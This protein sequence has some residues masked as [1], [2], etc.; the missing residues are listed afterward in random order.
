MLRRW[1]HGIELMVSCDALWGLQ[2]LSVHARRSGVIWTQWLCAGCVGDAPLCH[3]DP[4]D[5]LPVSAATQ[6]LLASVG[7]PVC[8]LS[9]V[10]VGPLSSTPP[11]S[12]PCRPP[13]RLWGPPVPSHTVS[14][15]LIL[16]EKPDSWVKG[17]CC[18]W[19]SR[20][21][22]QHTA[23]WKATGLDSKCVSHW[24]RAKW[25]E[26]NFSGAI[27]ASKNGSWLIRIW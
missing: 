19:Y 16:K 27:W 18:T 17:G 13:S 6:D 8:L 9:S 5:F 22:S 26:H 21:H 2:Q 23:A 15:V 11:R 7:W 12:G 14:L 4:T 24:W 20:L 3:K 25:E 10:S 1:H